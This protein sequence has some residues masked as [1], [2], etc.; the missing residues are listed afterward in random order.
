MSK[1]DRW[2][3]AGISLV[4]GILFAIGAWAVSGK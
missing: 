4:C 1:T 3:L 2:W